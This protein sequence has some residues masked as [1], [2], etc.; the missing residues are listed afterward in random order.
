LAE[1]DAGIRLTNFAYPYNAT[2]LK[3]KQRLEMHFS[4]CRGGVPGVNVGRV[5]LGFLRAIE[6]CD[7]LTD[8]AR[9][10]AWIAEAVRR[11]GWLIFFTHGVTDEAEPWRCT[12]ELLESAICAARDLGC[13]TATVA[14]AMVR[15]AQGDA[16]GRR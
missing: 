7:D 12:P 2:S 9:V 15:L 11:R 4:S 16:R 14:D 1:R 3:A 6:L 10:R 5:D 8:P 13:E